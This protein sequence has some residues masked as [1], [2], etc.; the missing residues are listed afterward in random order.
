MAR[1]ARLD[2]FARDVAAMIDAEFSPEARSRTLAE[3]ARVEIE[4][5]N[6]INRTALGS[7]PR[8]DQ[9]VDGQKGAPLTS[10][11]AGGRIFA[12]WH[13]LGATLQ[14]VRQSLR[15]AAPV[16]DGRRGRV[17]VAFQPHLYSRTRLF[18]AEFGASLSLA[19]EVM[20]LDVYGAREDPEPGVGPALISDA[21]T[22]PAGRVHRAPS[23]ERT[24]AAIAA[25][26]TDGDVVITMGAGDVT[27][28]GPEI[29]R[30]LAGEG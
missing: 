4:R 6:V 15:E 28:L 1:P 10:V 27:A 7:E 16:R 19:D 17:L 5:A 14:Y 3:T 11:K 9:Y 26:A 8:Y 24:P 29:L 18:A 2:P 30:E 25:L 22:L 23:W 12:E 13:F 20:V 21:V